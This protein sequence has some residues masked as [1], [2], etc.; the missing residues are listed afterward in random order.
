MHTEPTLP[1]GRQRPAEVPR[2][3]IYIRRRPEESVL[4]GVV[5]PAL[6]GFLAHARARDRVVPRFV[7]RELR[8][9]LSCGILAHGFVRVRCDACAC[10]RL[11]AFSCKGR[12]FLHFVPE[13]GSLLLLGVSLVGFEIRRRP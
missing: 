3:R 13:P 7:E 10:E 11:V 9:L 6:E 2:D 1:R 12:A 5:H 8:A 4:Y